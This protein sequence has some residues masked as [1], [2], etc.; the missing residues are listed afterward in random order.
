MT[1]YNDQDYASDFT[2]APPQRVRFGTRD[3][4]T[5]PVSWAEQGLQWL[6]EQQPQIFAAMMLAILGIEKKRRGN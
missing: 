6:R 1:S 3:D 5:M 4:D 2:A